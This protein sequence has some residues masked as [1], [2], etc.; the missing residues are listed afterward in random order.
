M[1]VLLSSF[2]LVFLL[3]FQQQ[4]VTHENHAASIATSFFI[5]LAQTAF[6]RGA[7]AGDFWW[8]VT[9]LGAGGAAGASLSIVVHK[10]IFRRKRAT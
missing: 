5:A 10:R 8:T 7:V 6:I 3:G 4:N 2:C 1:D 9:C